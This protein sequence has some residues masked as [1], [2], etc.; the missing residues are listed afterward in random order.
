[1]AGARQEL[2]MDWRGGAPE[3]GLWD[4][5]GGGLLPRRSLGMRAA[6]HWTCLSQN[7]AR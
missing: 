6:P 1:M 5:E 2:R 4:S 7:R 3:V